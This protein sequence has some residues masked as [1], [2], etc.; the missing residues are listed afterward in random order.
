MLSCWLLAV[1]GL[2]WWMIS[3]GWLAENWC[4]WSGCLLY[5]WVVE[6]GKVGTYA[7]ACWKWPAGR[8]V[9][10][11]VRGGQAAVYTGGVCTAA[12]PG[13]PARKCRGDAVHH[14]PLPP[15]CVPL[16]LKQKH[17]RFSSI[18]YMKYLRLLVLID[19]LMSAFFFLPHIFFSVLILPDILFSCTFSFNF[20][21]SPYFLAC[22]YFSPADFPA[23]SF[24]SKFA[25]S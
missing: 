4:W 8:A 5:I 24:F 7:D 17:G 20:P 6:G 22:S 15:L 10:L 21:A 19:I 2:L 25:S 9:H 11:A 18:H 1:E 16:H 12:N 14:A 23:Y 3:C 13:K